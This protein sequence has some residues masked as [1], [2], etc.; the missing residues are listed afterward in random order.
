[1]WGNTLLG[2]AMSVP[3][4]LIKHSNF[5]VYIIVSKANK[6]KFICKWGSFLSCMWKII[7]E[8]KVAFSLFF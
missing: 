7:N 3:G 8:C 4:P 6:L 2:L 1:M 5:L